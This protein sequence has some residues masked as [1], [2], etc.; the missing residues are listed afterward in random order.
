MPLADS[1]PR[2]QGPYTHPS[3][4][5]RRGGHSGCQEGVS[6]DRPRDPA[7]PTIRGGCVCRSSQMSRRAF[8]LVLC[9][10]TAL[11]TRGVEPPAQNARPRPGIPTMVPV[12]VMSFNIRYATAP[13]GE[14]A[15]DRRKEFLAETV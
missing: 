3:V 4:I 2:D 10:T 5:R 8:S 9:V 13:D 1:S 15:W 7:V 14:N 6:A 11:T 12:R